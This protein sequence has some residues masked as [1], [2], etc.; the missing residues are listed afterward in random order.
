MPPRRDPFDDFD[1]HVADEVDTDYPAKYPANRIP[2]PPSVVERLAG[3]EDAEIAE[4]NR[5]L[6]EVNMDLEKWRRAISEND[7][8]HLEGTLTIREPG[9]GATFK[10]SVVLRS[11]LRLGRTDVEIVDVGL[12]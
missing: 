1:F 3:L 12:G 7:S 6:D 11:G 4:R 2:P 5:R 10:G 8:G 9:K